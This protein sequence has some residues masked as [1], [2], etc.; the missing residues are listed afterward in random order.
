MS[1]AIPE[2]YLARAGEFVNRNLHL[3]DLRSFVA[4]AIMETEQKQA[5][6]LAGLTKR[7]ADTLKFIDAFQTER[8]C[9]PTYSEIAE[10]IGLTSKGRAHRIVSGLIERGRL[11]HVPNRARSF[12]IGRRAA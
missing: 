7:Q 3:C 2:Q 9:S 4:V 12:V 6:P 10:G 5:L 1:T 11:S 8:E